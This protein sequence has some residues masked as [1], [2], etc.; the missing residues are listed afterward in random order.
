[1]KIKIYDAESKKNMIFFFPTSAVKSRFLWR[2]AGSEYEKYRLLSKKMYK[3]LKA[4]IKEN[5]HFDFVDI[6]SN[7]GDKIKIR[8]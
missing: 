3:N 4:Y 8:M 2:L 1:M 7:D 5:G 6:D